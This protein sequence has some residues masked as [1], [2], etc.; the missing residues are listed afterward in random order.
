VTRVIGLTGGIASGK[1]TVAAMLRQLGAAV[2]D[3]DALARQIVLPG[4]PALAELAKRFGPEILDTSGCLDRKRLGEI[5]FSDA[6]ARA[7][8]NRIT[9]PRIASAGQAEIA[10]HAAAGA[11]VVFYEAALLVENGAH[12]ALDGLVVV[13]IPPAMQV[14]RMVSRDGLD[15]AAAEAR[16]AAQLPLSAKTAVATHVIDNSGSEA[17]TRAQVEVLWRALPTPAETT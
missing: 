8:L 17:Q 1:S 10:R 9:H 15:R 16:L 11:P 2:V 13:A 4:T 3:A 14:D 5:V 12:R 7:D 6:E